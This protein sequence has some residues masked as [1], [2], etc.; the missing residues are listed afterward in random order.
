MAGLSQNRDNCEH[1]AKRKKKFKHVFKAQ[2]TP[3]HPCDVTLVVNGGKAEF[4][5]HGDLLSEASPFFQKLLRSGMKESKEGVVRL[6]MFSEAVMALTLEFIYTGGAQISTLE[7]AEGL[8]VLADYLFLPK[9]KTL[10]KG[11]AVSLQTLNMSNCIS[12]YNFAEIYRC[13]ELFSNARRFILSN[14][15]SVAKT[16]EFMNMSS[17]RIEM[18]IS[19]DDI[20]VSAEEDVFKIILTWINRDKSERKKHFAELFRHVRLVYVTRDYL[21]SDVV[22]NELVRDGEGCLDL[23]KDAMKLIDFKSYHNLSARPRKCLE[24]AVIVF[25]LEEHILGYFPREDKLC[26]MGKN[27][28]SR[29]FSI[30]DPRSQLV[31]CHGKVYSIFPPLQQLICYDPFCNIWASLPFSKGRNLRQIFPGNEDEMFALVSQFTENHPNDGPPYISKYRPESNTWEDISPLKFTMVSLSSQEGMCILVNDS[32]IYFIG[33]RRMRNHWRRPVLKNV[34]R[35]D[36][37]K[38]QGEKLANLQLERAFACGAFAHGKIFV[39]GGINRYEMISNTCEVYDEKTNEWQLIASL[40]MPPD[41]VPQI[42]SVDD[43]L[44]AVARFY[45]SDSLGAKIE[46]YDSD[47]ENWNERIEIPMR[48]NAAEV[49]KYPPLCDC[50]DRVNACSMRIFKGLL[51]ECKIQKKAS[52]SLVVSRDK[53]ETPCARRCLIM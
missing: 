18:W 32:F 14:F 22:T 19:N 51:S 13:E 15:T 35:Y 48:V 52:A 36:L 11:V 46:C 20:N 29:E 39:T 10:A 17:K 12:S 37:V 43:I 2:E 16:E 8:I 34:Y 4:K 5:A 40:H 31:P 23:V 47:K 44:Y 9:L 6:E 24:T 45:V 7:I 28:F 25:S 3:Q 26:R 27:T 42:L 1:D 49:R 21:H 50:S 30:C 41:T 53:S 33:G 38:K